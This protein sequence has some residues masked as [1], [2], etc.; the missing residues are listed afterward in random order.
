VNVAEA[1][2]LGAVKLT[3]R[4][5]ISGVLASCTV[6]SV[7]L[8][9]ILPTNRISLYTLASF[10]VAVIIIE[11]GVKNGWIFYIVTCAVSFFVVPWK[12]AIIPFILFF[13]IYGIIKYYI[14]KLD[15]ILPEYLLK[16][17]Y[18]N[19]CLIFS[20][21]LI[22]E[23]FLRVTVIELHWKIIAVSG[24]QVVFLVYD[25]VYSLFIRYYKTRIRK[26]LKL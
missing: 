22:K 4:L 17:L 7:F 21:L 6:V 15:R 19:T 5:A 11:F 26:I 10:F 1:I 18:F 3:K 13:G 20:L 23:V 24:L 8:S 25:Y 12:T 16:Y 14:E 2:L 9:T